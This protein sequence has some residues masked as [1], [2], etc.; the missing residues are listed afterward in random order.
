MI[1]EEC[2]AL[3]F[4]PPSLLFM[5]LL[6]LSGFVVFIALCLLR[7]MEPYSKSYW[8]CQYCTYVDSSNRSSLC[9]DFSTDDAVHQWKMYI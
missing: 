5:F 8:S 1:K 9:S 7:S 3:F 4:C 2:N 6:P